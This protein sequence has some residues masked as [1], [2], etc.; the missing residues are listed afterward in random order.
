MVEAS[1]A[2]EIM[3]VEEGMEVDEEISVS[4]PSKE[5]RASDLYLD[6]VSLSTRFP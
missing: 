1:A 5:P 3:E 2:D 6:T 4:P